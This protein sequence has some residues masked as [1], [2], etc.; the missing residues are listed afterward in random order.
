MSK[1]STALVT[2]NSIHLSSPPA[3]P[4]VHTH[5]ALTRSQN[6][7]HASFVCAGSHLG[8]R[9]G[10][11]LNLTNV[12]RTP[13]YPN[14]AAFDFSTEN[15]TDP[16]SWENPGDV[17]FVY[18]SC[19]AI[20]CWIEPRCTV[21]SV[22]GSEVKLK[23][24]GN[25]SCYHRLYYY[26]QCF[27]NGRGPGRTGYRGMNPTSI[28]NVASNWSYAGQFYYD[29]AG[30]SIG[31]IPRPGETVRRLRDLFIFGYFPRVS[32]PHPTPSRAV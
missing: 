19:D 18:T 25:E 23:Q 32:R 1:S 4:K 20:N 2:P 6:G 26:A 22:S 12:T 21:E 15:A 13:L 5:P 16:A 27:S 10:H 3:S 29:R 11:C 31:Y 8:S 14:G 24:D 28:E 17:E 9:E 30:G 7:P